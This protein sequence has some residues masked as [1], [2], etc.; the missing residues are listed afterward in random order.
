MILCYSNYQFFL[1]PPFRYRSMSMI[2]CERER[3]GKMGLTSFTRNKSLRPN[4]I[5]HTI[6][7]EEHRT[8]E[9]L[10]RIPC[11][12]TRHHR[13][14]HTKP[15]SL[16]VTHPQCHGSSPFVAIREG[17]Q[18]SSP[19]MQTALATTMVR[20]RR[21]ASADIPTG[22]KSEELYCS[23]GNLQIFAPS[24]SKPKLPTIILV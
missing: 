12:I 8:R 5:P 6:P 23:T 18:K 14:T 1:H 15:Q 22:K 24:V 16:E 3:E 13:Q 9:L 11:N 19:K 10:L 20:I 17:N 2:G 21:P 4:N 7:R